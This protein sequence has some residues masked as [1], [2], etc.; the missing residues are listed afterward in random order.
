MPQTLTVGAALLWL[1]T[2]QRCFGPDV[3]LCFVHGPAPPQGR[4]W[5]PVP[6][7]DQG[8]LMVST[9]ST[10]HTTDV[11]GSTLVLLYENTP[12]LPGGTVREPLIVTYDYVQKNAQWKVLD[13]RDSEGNDQA[14]PM[15]RSFS[16]VAELM[17]AT[18][19]LHGKR[20]LVFQR[21]DFC[22]QERHELASS[23]LGFWSMDGTLAYV[24]CACTRRRVVTRDEWE[25]AHPQ[26]QRQGGL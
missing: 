2:V 15:Q 26:A 11:T 22:Q 4:L 5:L 17:Q 21:R 24:V 10:M 25:K 23:S 7:H 16:D 3:P 9:L 18:Q 6:G 20:A 13:V 12:V 8:G 14:L 1:E 19:A